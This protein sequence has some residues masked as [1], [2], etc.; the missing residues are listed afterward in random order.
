MAFRELTSSLTP[1][2]VTGLFFLAAMLAWHINA[3]S[4]RS[5]RDK[6]WKSVAILAFIFLMVSLLVMLITI[7]TASILFS[8]DIADVFLGPNR[9]DFACFLDRSGSCSRCDELVGRCPEWS[10]EDVKKVLQSQAKSSATLAAMFLI[11][12]GS[13][14]RFGFNLRRHNSMYQIDYV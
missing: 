14:I 12:A 3:V 10:T 6:R 7:F 13:A 5:T 1:T 9:G 8:V 4:I 2:C 11:Y